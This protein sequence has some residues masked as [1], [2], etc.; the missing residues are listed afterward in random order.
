MAPV[1]APLHFLSSEVPALLPLALLPYQSPT[2]LIISINEVGFNWDDM[3]NAITPYLSSLSLL[4]FIDRTTIILDETLLTYL[5]CDKQVT[6]PLLVFAGVSSVPVGQ[7]YNL[8]SRHAWR[9]LA[10]FDTTFSLTGDDIEMD[11]LE[12]MDVVVWEDMEAED[13]P[14]FAL[15]LQSVDCINYLHWTPHA[16]REELEFFEEGKVRR[17]LISTYNEDVYLANDLLSAILYLTTK[18]DLDVVFLDTS[19][20]MIVLSELRFHLTGRADVWRQ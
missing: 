17:M 11:P 8:L 1:N 4:F 2:A 3:V 10:L 18:I 16:I 20:P 7:F 14:V 6:T 5:F 13:W 12:P 9:S 19:V 15:I